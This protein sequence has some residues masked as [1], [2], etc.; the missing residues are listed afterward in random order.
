MHDKINFITNQV[1]ELEHFRMQASKIYARI[2][3][4]QQ[5]VLCNLEIIENYFQESN[6][7][8]ENVFQKEREVKATRT[9]FQKAV[10]SSLNEE[11]GKIRNYLFL[12][13]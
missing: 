12:N 1:V 2:E 6:K 7:S 13:R 3:E 4:E 9:T 10:A 5:K 8:M 11:I